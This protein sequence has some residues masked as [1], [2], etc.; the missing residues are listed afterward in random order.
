MVDAVIVSNLDLIRKIPT[1]RSVHES[2]QAER[3]LSEAGDIVAGEGDSAVVTA[4]ADG[5]VGRVTLNRPEAGNAIN[6]ALGR[7]LELALRELAA[8]EGVHVI[9]IR[10]AGGNFSVGGDF[11]ELESLR[12]RG[13]AAL[14][15]LFENFGR[16]CAAIAELPVPVVAAVEGYA[17]AGGFELMQ[18]SDIALVR[19]DAKLA[20]NHANFGQVPGGGSSQRLPRLAGRQRALGHILSGERLSGAQAADWGLA[21][22]SF[23]PG[24]FDAGVEEFARRIAA[25]DRDALAKIKRL[26]YDGLRM[27]LADGL[28]MERAA[29]VEHVCGDTAGT[30]IAAF[31]RRAGNQGVRT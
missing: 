10:G 11:R 7:Q 9:V 5:P 26:I 13:P 3:P 6:V 19:A 14:A 30:G 16:A 2:L 31:T 29:V 21:Y 28:A 17:M 25:K 15:P 23:P 8:E 20:D 1:S 22:R 18:A 12:A 27:P 4:S 24:E